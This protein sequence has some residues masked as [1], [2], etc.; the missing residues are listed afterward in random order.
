M[1]TKT[2][3]KRMNETNIILRIKGFLLSKVADIW[4]SDQIKLMTFTAATVYV[5]LSKI[6]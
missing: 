4:R 5:L 2:K 1:K 6:T 3:K